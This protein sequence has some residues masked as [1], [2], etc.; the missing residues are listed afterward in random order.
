MST[1]RAFD[2]ACMGRAAVDLY[3]EQVGCRLEDVSTFA[4]YLGGSPANTAVGVSRLGL[5]SAMLSR[6]G[7]EQNGRFVREALEREGVDVSQVTTDPN[8]LTALVFLALRG[9]D[10]FPHI[11]YRDRCADMAIAPAHISPEFIASCGALLLSGTHLSQEGPRS[12]CDKAVEFAK[13][14]GTRVILDIDY[15]PVLWGLARPGEGAARYVSSDAVTAA[16]APLLRH[17]DLIVGTEEEI[18]VAGGS[19]DTREALR[20]I[21]SRSAATI[22]LKRGPLGCIAYSDAIPDRLEDGVQGAGFP[23]EVFNTLGA[24]DAF[25]AGFLRGWLKGEP[26]EQCCRFANACG[27]IV[28]SRHGC[29]PAM[30]TWKELQFFLARGVVNPRL[31]ED[32]ELEHVHRATTRLAPAVD[33]HVLAFDHRGHFEEL[34]RA[35]GRDAAD[36]SR[37]KSLVAEAFERVALDRPGAGIVLD[38]RYGA[39]PLARLTG[40]GLWIA[41]PVEQP[42]T[43]PLAFEGGPNIGLALRHWPTEH[44]AKCLVYFS[45]SDPKPLRDA[46]LAAIHALAEACAETGRELLLEVIPPGA[47]NDPALVPAAVEAIYDDGIRPDWWKLPPSPDAAS[48]QRVAAIV[49][50][51]DPFCRGAVVLGMESDVE[52]LAGGFKAAAACPLVRG[53]AVGRTIFA[54]AAQGWF[55]GRMSDAEAVDAV[56]T[57]YEAIIA[58]WEAAKDAHASETKNSPIEEN[59]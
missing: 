22:V 45:A 30:P 16:L 44:V 28:V 15:R 12:A 50:A 57:R 2:V 5:R 8:R 36:I 23:I 49:R 40:R 10:D 18:R 31:R 52:S 32:A 25:M 37:F 3:G 19:V 39:Q 48:W 41:R 59:A 21:R 53:F 14:S 34:A 6:V 58:L 1:A 26:L 54:D 42:N 38:E 17:C 9:D 55:A 20:S 27:A 46:Q 33:P 24:G 47:L 43:I 51:R 29:S 13:R 4:K 35:S 11:F 7:D 56:A